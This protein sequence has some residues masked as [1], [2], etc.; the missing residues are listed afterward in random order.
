MTEKTPKKSSF[1]RDIVDI[2]FIVPKEKYTFTYCPVDSRQYFNAGVNRER[3]FKK[4]MSELFS[5]D[6]YVG[7]HI[8][9]R[10]E[11]SRSGRLHLHGTIEFTDKDCIKRF[12]IN[13]IHDLLEYAK[14]EIDTIGDM[15]DWHNYLNKQ[16]DYF[17]WHIDNVIIIRDRKAM[18]VIT[19]QKKEA[20]KRHIDDYF[21]EVI[22][23]T[24]P[25]KYVDDH[26]NGIYWQDN[27]EKPNKI[28]DDYSS[29]DSSIESS[30]SDSD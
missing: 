30:D 11:V 28:P 1:K 6:Q 22:K 27:K 12:Y 9:C 13:I 8:W 2:E 17:D 20:P 19:R 7:I 24:K 14:V 23:K 4:H 29:R 15:K 25:K 5:T 10:P 18:E 21:D 16:I 26:L 3:Y